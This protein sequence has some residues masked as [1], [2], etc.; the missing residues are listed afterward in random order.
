MSTPENDTASAVLKDALT[1]QIGAFAPKPTSTSDGQVE[2]SSSLWK[3]GDTK[4][5]AGIWEASPGTFT[6]RRDGYHEICQILSGR[7]T[8]EPTGEEPFDIAAGDTFVTPSGWTGTWH[9]HETM[10][11]VYVTITV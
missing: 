5:D 3:S 9:V 10:R 2:A 6:A 11:K 7:A 4:S 8:I 1:A